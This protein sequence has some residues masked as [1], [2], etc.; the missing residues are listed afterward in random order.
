MENMRSMFRDISDWTIIAEKTI[1]DFS[2]NENPIEVIE[3]EIGTL[4]Y[5]ELDFP[6]QHYNV[7]H[8]PITRWITRKEYEY[9]RANEGTIIW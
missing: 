2:E 8:T 5:E 7:R 3:V 6:H 1:H 9:L 4:D